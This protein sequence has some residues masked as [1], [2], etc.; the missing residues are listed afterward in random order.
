MTAA[1]F[2]ADFYP[3]AS[4]GLRPLRAEQ[5]EPIARQLAAIDPWL[6]LGFA[7]EA[8]ATYLLR[9]D[10]GLYRYEILDAQGATAGVVAVRHPWLRGP[11]LEL[12]AVF[13]PHQGRGLGGAALEWFERQARLTSANAWVLVSA[14]NQGAY[15]LYRRYGFVEIGPIPDLIKPGQNEILLRKSLNQTPELVGRHSHADN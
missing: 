1:P 7:A 15:G 13:P 3:L 12:F 10:G 8:L 2:A 5:A 14:F 9:A 4:G 6:A 11:Y